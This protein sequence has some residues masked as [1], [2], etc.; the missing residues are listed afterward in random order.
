MFLKQL[1]NILNNSSFRLIVLYSSLY[2]TSSLVLLGFIF[3]STMTYVFQQIDHHIEYDRQTLM[4]IYNQYGKEK[5]IESIDERLKRE[6]FDS[7]YLLYDSEKGILA[8]NLGNIPAEISDFGWYRINLHKCACKIAAHSNEAQILVK[9]LTTKEGES[10]QLIFLNGVDMNAA[11]QQQNLIINRMGWGLFIILILGIMGGF[12]ISRKTLRKIDLINTTILDIHDGDLDIRVPLR[13]TDDDYDLLAY[14]IN[15][16]LDQINILVANIQNISNHVSHDLRT[17][18][19]RMRGKLENILP[20]VNQQQVDNILT[21]IEE[22]DQLLAT[23]NAILRISKV[24]SGANTGSFSL[25]S[26]SQL[27]QDV[28]EFYEP[29]ANDKQISLSIQTHDKI[30]MNGDRDMLFQAI[31]NIVDN[32]IK[33][34]QDG[35]EIKLLSKTQNNKIILS[36]S[37]NGKGIPDDKKQKVFERFYQLSKHRGGNG[38][39]LGLSL[40][41]AII[42]LHK[43]EIKLKDNHPGLI[44]ELVFKHK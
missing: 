37:D 23:F 6:V 10:G 9:P 30:E 2:I 27:L 4:Q 22:T 26:I 7:I 1:N 24:E 33:Y 38:H 31:A 41:G 25:F 39:G 28:G 12:I 32:A 36:I 3:W 34:S 18:L 42:K 11:Q 5:L 43:G 19:T 15:Q 8:G 35:G 13:G 16:M 40:V 21:V 44:V 17:P 20:E 29:L 14:N